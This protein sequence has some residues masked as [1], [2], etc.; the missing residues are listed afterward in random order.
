MDGDEL[1]RCLTDRVQEL[2]HLAERSPQA[3]QLADDQP[4]PSGQLAHQLV[5]S[6]VLPRRSTGRLRLEEAV[7]LKS[8]L[9][10]VFEDGEPLA[11]D[12]LVRRRHPEVREVFHR[13]SMNTPLILLSYRYRIHLIPSVRTDSPKRSFL[14]DKRS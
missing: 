7:D 8:L 6:S 1:D 3:G 5:K 2:D 10:R 4:V 13:L 14:S 11:P 12:I 9:P